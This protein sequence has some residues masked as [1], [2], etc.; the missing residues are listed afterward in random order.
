M[1]CTTRKRL[2]HSTGVVLS[3]TVVLL[4]VLFTSNGPPMTF[5][6]GKCTQVP[7]M[8]VDEELK[9][10]IR[11]HHDIEQENFKHMK[12]ALKHYESLANRS[13]ANGH[14]VDIYSADVNQTG[15]HVMAYFSF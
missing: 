6:G 2:L 5:I 4:E 12:K 14:L 1:A 3:I 9:N 13:A 8:I 7:G 15:L 10:P 11:S